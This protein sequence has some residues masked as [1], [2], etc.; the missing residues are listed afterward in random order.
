MLFAYSVMMIAKWFLTQTI[1]FIAIHVVILIVI[2]VVFLQE[3]LADDA[4]AV[5]VFWITLSE[6]LVLK[7]IFDLIKFVNL[8]YL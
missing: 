7:L 2:C 4:R 3:E 6:I 5:M 1:I 8:N